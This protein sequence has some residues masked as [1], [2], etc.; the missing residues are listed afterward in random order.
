MMNDST[1]ELA[2]IDDVQKKP[3]N[4]GSC[5]RIGIVMIGVGFCLGI[6]IAIGYGIGY[7]EPSF[8]PELTDNVVKPMSWLSTPCEIYS[9]PLCPSTFTR[10][11]LL[12]VSLDGFRAEYLLRNFTPN[13]KKLSECGVHAPYMFPVFP[14]YTFPNHYSIVT[15]MYPESHGIIANSMYDPDMGESFS[16]DSEQKF[17]PQWW[18]AA[19]PI[20]VTAINNG[21][22]T[23][24]FF[25]PGE[26]VEI[27][28]VRPTY[29]HRYD[30]AV[31]YE[32]RIDEV[33][34][35]LTLPEEKR[36]AFMTAYFEEPDG[37][38]HDFGP[39]ADEVDAMLQYM[40]T[41][42]GAL[43]DGIM[44][45]QLDK[46]VDIIILAD[47]GM[48]PRDCSRVFF[49]HDYINTYDYYIRYGAITRLDPKWD[50][51]ISDPDEI[52][53]SFQC[54]DPNITSY[55]KWDLPKNWHYANNVR[56][57]PSI[58]V[59]DVGWTISGRN[60]SSYKEEYCSGGTHGFNNKGIQM[61]SLFLAHGPS[62]KQNMAIDPFLAIELY[63]LMTEILGIPESRN[64]A[65]TGS[66]SHILR[67]P[68]PLVA[69]TLIVQE[70]TACT[71]PADYEARILEDSSGC[72]CDAVADLEV[73]DSRLDLTQT[74]V[75]DSHAKHLPFGVPNINFTD[76]IHCMVTQYEYVGV[77]DNLHK[78][79]LWMAYTFD[80]QVDG[81]VRH[82][83]PE[84][85]VRADVRVDDANTASCA[86]YIGSAYQTGFLA[87][88]GLWEKLDQQMDA[89]ITSNMVPFSTK[90]IADIWTYLTE[91]IIKWADLYNGVNVIA[92]PIFDYSFDGLRDDAL[93]RLNYTDSVKFGSGSLVPSHHFVIVT[94]C[95]G[96][97]QYGVECAEDLE[98]LPFIVRNSDGIETCQEPDRYLQLEL[99]TV[100]D[101]ELLTDL[102]FFPD[103]SLAKAIQLKLFTARTLWPSS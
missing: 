25:W 34:S 15:G 43:M 56:I 14:S 39:Y 77:V 9:E 73:Y 88:P 79:P 10:R 13:I 65:T 53:A 21:L 98:V 99:A 18:N 31:S 61:E 81:G 83:F 92:G 7:N 24:G 12:L 35:W 28:G 30:G 58:V 63:P 64:N 16:L 75:T 95:P 2:G 49:L 86:D 93:L 60:D 29:Y 66:L 17:N 40:D 26:D 42:I 50:A 67:N 48:A 96:E 55:V 78:V 84:N 19:E 38:G 101:I 87:T 89:L 46:C 82:S 6:G 100:R 37:A 57:E 90:Y 51:V 44:N 59:A 47:H 72:T 1:Y 45:L 97:T 41:V 62:F 33:L 54:Q 23:G 8:E 27:R 36:P 102:H 70:K 32:Q 11:P 69:P 68:K 94:R 80:R 85:C 3:G 22:K 76:S 4:N 5:I 74:E 52:V 71:Y 103:L 91:K 20:W